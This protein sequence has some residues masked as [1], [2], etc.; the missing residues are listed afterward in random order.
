MM[1]NIKSV[2]LSLGGASLMTI[3]VALVMGW[4]AFTMTTQRSPKLDP[5]NFTARVD[6]TQS[7]DSL[8]TLCSN[9]ARGYDAQGAHIAF[10]SR[11]IDDILTKIAIFF[12]GWNIVA[13]A[14]FF[15]IFRTARKY[16]QQ[17]GVAP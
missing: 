17:T 4:F 9:L 6:A 16:E 7:C 3:V 14:G 11:G 10:L 5:P 8:K 12:L 13:T 2:S 1:T 15:Y